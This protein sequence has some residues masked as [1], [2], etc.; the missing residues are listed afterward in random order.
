MFIPAVKNHYQELITLFAELYKYPDEQVT[1]EVMNGTAEQEMHRG[2]VSC[3]LPVTTRLSLQQLIT[4]ENNVQK[5]FMT[6]FSGLSKP[7][8][9][10]VES[11]YKPWS[12]DADAPKQLAKKRGYYMGDSALHMNH[13]LS[14]YGF[15]VPEEFKMMPDH[16]VIELEFYAFLLG[17]DTR[18]AVTFYNEHLDW[19]K[20]FEKEMNKL[21]GVPFYQEVTRRLRNLLSI[22]PLEII[23]GEE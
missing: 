19:I 2:F 12:T 13:L 15:G 21:G 7:F 16:L 10:P 1:E 4:A 23:N 14:C 22:H 11:L 8:S 6:A 9:P 20:D 17:E 18:M 3:S 5:Q